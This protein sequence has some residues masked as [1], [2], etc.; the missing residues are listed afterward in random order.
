LYTASGIGRRA[1]LSRR[2]EWRTVSKALLTRISDV[3]EYKFKFYYILFSHKWH[4]ALISFNK[5]NAALKLQYCRRSNIELLV[6]DQLRPVSD[7]SQD[8][9]RTLFGNAAL[10]GCIG[11]RE[12]REVPP[13][14]ACIQPD[15][16]G[17]DI[18]ADLTSNQVFT[19]HLHGVLM[20]RT[21]WEIEN[22]FVVGVGDP[23]S[24]ETSLNWIKYG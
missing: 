22:C 13:S 10:L 14:V 7:A 6:C 18:Y 24:S 19:L 17:T 8:D 16:N 4:N 5:S 21:R 2:V 3:G 20:R 1:I 9:M 11:N 12:L 23:N 15:E